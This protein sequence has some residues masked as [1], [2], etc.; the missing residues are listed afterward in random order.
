MKEN[1]I[2]PRVKFVQADFDKRVK[3]RLNL[4]RSWLLNL[5][6]YAGNQQSQ[7]LPTGEITEA[8]KRYSWQESEVYNHIAPII[9]ARLSKFANIRGMVSV[10][11]ATGDPADIETAKFSTK[12]L[13]SVEE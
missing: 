2:D 13:R 7:V 8:D 12:L 6:F 11:P 3:E 9:E 10:V 1:K 5:N 4:E